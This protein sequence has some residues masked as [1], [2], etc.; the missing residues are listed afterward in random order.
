MCGFKI[1]S[2]FNL[3]RFGVETPNEYVKQECNT[4]EGVFT[5]PSSVFTSYFV[6]CN[7]LH[8]LECVVWLFSPCQYCQNYAK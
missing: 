1:L 3:L 2:L 6:F 7:T 4:T 5:T 8:N